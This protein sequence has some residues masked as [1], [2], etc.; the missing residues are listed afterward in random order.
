MSKRSDIRYFSISSLTAYANSP[1]IH[2]RG[3][4]AKLAK[5]IRRHNQLTP[6]L[7]DEN[8]VLIDGHAVVEAMKLNGAEEVAGIIIEGRD[9]A[10]IRAIRLA[11]N[12]V[13]QSVKWNNEKLRNELNDLLDL[14][15]DLVFT[16]FDSLD[17]DM[18]LRFEDPESGVVEIAP[19][20]PDPNAVP[21]TRPGDLWVCGPHRVLCG[22]ARDAGQVARLMGDRKAQMVFSDPPYN[23]KIDGFAAG[24][25]RHR[26]FAMASGE[27]SQPEFT[28][29]LRAFLLTSA[30]VCQDGAILFVCMDWRHIGEVLLASEAAKLR[31]MNVVVWA[32]T[33]AGM[34]SFYRSQHEFVFVLKVGEGS[35]VNNFEL[36][37]KGRSRSNV[38]TYKGMTSPGGERNELLHLHPTVKPVTLVIDAIRDVSHLHNV[39]LDPFLGSGTTLIAAEVAGRFCCGMEIDPLYVDVALRRWEDETGYHAVLEATGETFTQCAKQAGGEASVVLKRLAPPQQLLGGKG[40]VA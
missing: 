40:E 13:P 8:L 35:H 10:D 39:V 2:S 32:K 22:D 38:W 29:F 5:L 28:S 16:G 4:I 17:I 12:R 9:P 1:R 30:A 3:K 37:Q 34:G 20:E 26:E 19:D 24:K 6:V 33:N 23:V 36:G 11:I 21:V 15:Y 25:G 14:S 7:L 18:I 27:M 31:L